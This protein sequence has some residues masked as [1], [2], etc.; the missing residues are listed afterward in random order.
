MKISFSRARE[1][2]LSH[3]SS[4]ISRDRDSCQCLLAPLAMATPLHSFPPPPNT[5]LDVEEVRCE[6]FLKVTTWILRRALCPRCLVTCSP[7]NQR[8]TRY[9]QIRYIYK[10]GIYNAYIYIQ[11]RYIL[12]TYMINCTIN[13]T[14][15]IF[16]LKKSYLSP[17]CPKLH[18]F[19]S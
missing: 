15:H 12:S 5:R 8:C 18:N 17:R 1:K 4:R 10:P 14:V 19:F 13:G 7:H 2:N 9:T 11:T 16:F 6:I 3:F